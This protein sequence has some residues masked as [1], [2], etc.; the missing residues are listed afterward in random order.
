ML[1]EKA[2]IREPGTTYFSSYVEYR[3]N[4]SDGLNEK[5]SHRLRHSHA[6]SLAGGNVWEGLG[7]GCITENGLEVSKAHSVPS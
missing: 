1:S 3:L 6:S 2:R 5:C 7:G 4:K